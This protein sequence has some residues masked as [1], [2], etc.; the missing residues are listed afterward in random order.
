M[1]RIVK[2][3][4]HSGYT[5][6]ERPTAVEMDGKRLEITEIIT[7]SRTPTGRK[8]TVRFKDGKVIDLDYDENEDEWELTD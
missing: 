2:V 5:Y 8:F 6:A 7:E 1:G 4:C 3:E